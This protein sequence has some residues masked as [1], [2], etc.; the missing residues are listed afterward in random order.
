MS[1]EG[2]VSRQAPG[3]LFV[4]GE[5]AVI[6]P[7]TPAIIMA[8]D[9]YVR[10]T[11]SEPAGA[12]IVIVSDLLDGEARFRLQAGGGLVWCGPGD[13][14]RAR[15]VLACV[16]S[17][18]EVMH[19]QLAERGWSASGAHLSISS[20]LHDRGTKFGLGSSG[21]VTVATVAAL[22]AYH[23]LD[24]SP[25]ARFRLALIATARLNT[26]SSCADL[27]A[28]TWGGWIA[29]RAPDRAAVLAMAARRGIDE[30]LRAAW[31][32]FEVRRLPPPARLGIEI[33]WTGTPVSTDSLVSRLGRRHWRGST[34]HKR[35]MARMTDCVHASITALEQ[36]DRE[37]L[38]HRIR[39][40]R[41]ALAELDEAVGLGIFTPK[42]TALC[43]AA[44][45]L[46]GAAKPSGAGGGD[47]G[48]ALMPAEDDARIR[49]LR[50]RWATAGVRHLPLLPAEESTSERN[51]RNDR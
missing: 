33:G 2:T 39:G 48:I 6:E 1:A 47:C 35:F 14:E 49:K 26:R 3:K 9:R 13:G 29:Y 16:L 22:A 5:Y 18:I 32:G 45:A 11:V 28:S 21:A 15:S 24:L 34:A 36:G 10:V 40:S 38:L 8:V 51:V 31:P 20:E 50:N 23:G 27:A 19:T 7:G 12:D 25:E 4:S 41:R 37:T 43:E 46:G 17:V 44:E 30:T 42:L